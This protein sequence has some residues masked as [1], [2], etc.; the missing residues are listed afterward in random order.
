MDPAAKTDATQVLALWTG[1]G[2][3]PLTQFEEDA[4][5]VANAFHH[6]KASIFARNVRAEGWKEGT[7][8]SRSVATFCVLKSWEER[9]RVASDHYCEF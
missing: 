8:R 5:K 9:L 6:S 4:E 1:L 7:D 3:P 2:R